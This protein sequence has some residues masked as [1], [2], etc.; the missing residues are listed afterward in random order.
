MEGE[1][2]VP[3]APWSIKKEGD[4]IRKRQISIKKKRIDN[5][6]EIWRWRET[7]Q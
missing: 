5:R 4:K 6:I 1:P 7:R 2:P 3:P